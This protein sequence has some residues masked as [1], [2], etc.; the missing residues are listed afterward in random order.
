MTGDRAS[1]PFSR[2]MIGWVRHR[3][4]GAIPHALKYPMYML[5]LDLDELPGIVA[6]SRLM[7]QDRFNWLNFRRSDFFGDPQRALKTTVIE[8]IAQESSIEASS[9]W[10][11][12]MLTNLR[13]LGFL[14]NPVTFYYAFD[15]DDQL[16]AIMPEITNTP[17]RERFQY[18]LSSAP[19]SQ[20]ISPTYHSAKGSRFKLVKDFHISPFHPMNL[21]YDWRFS[22]P[23][24]RKNTIHLES[25]QSNAKIFDATLS[26]API[27]IRAATIRHTLIRFPVMAV[28]VSSG[29]YWHAL[30]LWLKGVTFHP[31][32]KNANKETTL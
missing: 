17:W 28:K 29:I 13:T 11:I 15:Q 25:W 3:R 21:N 2:L 7:S 10:R 8:K 14:S 32:P 12:C 30:K 22:Q 24:R 4:L 16:L 19:D 1:L 9:I 6:S 23:D 20:A 31:H 18:V 5:Y 26:L 27:P